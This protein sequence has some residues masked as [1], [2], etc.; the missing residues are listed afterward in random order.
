MNAPARSIF[1]VLVNTGYNPVMAKKLKVT[2]VRNSTGDVLPKEILERL[3]VEK[4]AS[5]FAI[6]DPEFI[7]QMEVAERMMREDS[8][9]LRKLA[10]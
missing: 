10:E 4:G 9:A 8:D 5:V 7:S 2:T 1:V 3:R 6:D